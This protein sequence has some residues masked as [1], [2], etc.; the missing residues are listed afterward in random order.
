MAPQARSWDS[1]RQTGA[2]PPADPGPPL[3]LIR[4]LD[5]QAG[6]HRYAVGRVP[7][8]ELVG[9]LG[10]AHSRRTP[11]AIPLWVVDAGRHVVTDEYRPRLRRPGPIVLARWAAAPLAWSGLEPLPDRLRSVAARAA[12]ARSHARARSLPVLGPVGAPAAYLAPVGDRDAVALYSAIH[13]VTGDQVL[14]RDQWELVQL[15]YVD[16][17]LLGFLTP[18]APLTGRVASRRPR[19]PWASRYGIEPRS[20]LHRAAEETAGAVLIPHAGQGPI[21]LPFRIAG[22]AAAPGAVS[23]VEVAVDGR[24]VGRARIGMD[25]LP[26]VET[27][28]TPDAPIS[29]FEFRLL[30]SHLEPGARTARIGCTIRDMAGAERRLP[31][32][33]VDVLPGG[34]DGGV[35]EARASELRRRAPWRP[36]DRGDRGGDP[37]RLLVFTHDLGYGGAQL[38]LLELLE[39][40]CGLLDLVVTVVAPDDGPLRERLEALGM[41]VHVTSGYPSQTVDLYEGKMAELLAWASPQRFDVAF[42]NTMIAFAGVDLAERLGVPSVF[43]IHESYDPEEFLSAHLPDGG[44]P[45]ARERGRRA[46]AGAGAVIF[47]AE[48]TRRQYVGHGHADRYLTLPYGIEYD[49]I[50]RFRATFDREAER[51]SLVGPGV[52]DVVLCLGTIEHRK[53]QSLLAK[54]FAHVGDR[55]PGAELVLVGKRS[56]DPYVEAVE[57]YARRV[58]L[59]GRIRT[60]A[61]DPEPYKWHGIADVLVCA[62]DLESLP[63]VV[64]E[65]MVFETPVLATDVFGLGELIDDGETGYLCESRDVRSLADGLER[66]LGADAGERAAVAAAGAR[67]VRTRH[68]PARYA[69]R[70]SQLVTDLLHGRELSA[71]DLVS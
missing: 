30:A 56:E 16:I 8:G 58:G 48:A 60:V 44:S 51:R 7:E 52:G 11:G 35:A 13:P 45:Y 71:P 63:R 17:A 50:D 31:E 25:N 70:V 36:E 19:L 37:I 67:R 69:E 34:V 65:G 55:F 23:E 53:S 10:S 38:Y 32:V 42:V 29:A 46:L 5:P 43:S 14:T 62:S 12:Q 61:I 64:L 6:R 15:G 40:L 27:N 26:L 59:R 66:V 21:E 33:A 57:E 24:R 41:A 47:E 49:E 1:G 3:G 22:W 68:D 39:R 18:I 54:A 9:E 28:P 2:A 20:D 4:S